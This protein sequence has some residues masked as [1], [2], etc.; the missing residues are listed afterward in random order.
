MSAPDLLAAITPIVDVFER[1]EIGHHIGGSV[2]S[3]VHGV[4][5]ATLD[6]DLVADLKLQHVEPLVAA[7]RPGYYLDEDTIRDAISKR[8]SF[9]V[10]HLDTMLKVDVFVLKGRPFDGQAFIRSRRDT[11]DDV[12]GS[13]LFFVASAE[14]VILNKLEW[15][16]IGHQV[17]ERQWNDV[18]G[19]LKVQARAL[20]FIYLRHWA[21]E[22][23]IDD[24]LVRAIEEAGV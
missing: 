14:D 6:V 16:R 23:G 4:P 15:Y 3:S 5:R 1:L 12:E 22:L 17:S 18:L 9:N 21:Q 24:L 20:D 2:A 8:S 10:I 19:V 13:R 7:L 11:L